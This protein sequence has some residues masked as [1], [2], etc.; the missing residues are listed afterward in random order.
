VPPKLLPLAKRIAH[1]VQ[2][3]RHRAMAARVRDVLMQLD[4]TQDPVRFSLYAVL[5]DPA[6][7]VDVRS[8]LATV[9]TGVPAELGVADVLE[10][11]PA[12]RI[13]LHLVETSYSADVTALTWRPNRPD[14]EGAV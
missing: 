8:W 12:T 14:P 11:A 2:R 5:V 4:P 6:D 1:E 9:A 3:R 13:S 10:A 7:E